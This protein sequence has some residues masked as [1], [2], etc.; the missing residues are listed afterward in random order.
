MPTKENDIVN[1]KLRFLVYGFFLFPLVYALGIGLVYVAPVKIKSLI[2]NW[3]AH[4][5]INIHTTKDVN[6]TRNNLINYIW[7]EDGFPY[8]KMPTEVSRYYQGK[9]AAG[10]HGSRR[11]DKLTITMKHGLHS[12]AYLIHGTNKSEELV[13][14]HHGHRKKT[15]QE[16]KNIKRILKK[17]YSVMV[18]NMPLFDGNNRPVVPIFPTKKIKLNKHN[19]LKYLQS[20]DFSPILYFVEPIAVGINYAQENINVKKIDM[21]GISGGGWT[22]TLYAAIDPR[23]NKS[24][25]VAGS[26]PLYLRE[27]KF[28]EHGDYEQWDPP[29]YETANYLDLYILGSVG[30]G[31]AHVQIL[32]KFDPCCFWGERHLKYVYS[33]ESKLRE[34]KEGEFKYFLD[35]THRGHKISKWAMDLILKE[36][37]SSKS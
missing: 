28:K 29:L 25:S 15:P 4:S 17:G 14:Y 18:F 34:L 27:E 12:I 30:A 16:R 23:L 21:V 7:K 10:L 1:Y 33:V 32:N 37:E 5:M 22:T 26:L 24:F 19:Q 8:R 20:E 31:R 9:E 35:D 2:L 36:M 6:I 3:T 11:V 13:I